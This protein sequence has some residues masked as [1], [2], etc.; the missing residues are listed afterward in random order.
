MLTTQYPHSLV[1]TASL[2]IE[3]G[4]KELKSTTIQDSRAPDEAVETSVRQVH[5]QYPVPAAF[6]IR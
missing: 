5:T 4:T 6:P 3:A 2:L 1:A